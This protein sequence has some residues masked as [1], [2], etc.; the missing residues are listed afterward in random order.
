M[1]MRKNHFGWAGSVSKFP[2]EITETGLAHAVGDKAE[3][4]CR[5]GDALEQRRGLMEAWAGYCEPRPRHMI[6]APMSNVTSVA[7]TRPA[8]SDRKHLSAPCSLNGTD[9]TTLDPLQMNRRCKNVASPV[10]SIASG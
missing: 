6:S 4:A 2:R 10:N 7:R 1:I 3:Q 5:R 9:F 8:S